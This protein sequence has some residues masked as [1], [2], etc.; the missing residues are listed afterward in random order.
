MQPNPLRLRSIHHVEFW[1]G[2]AK[3]AA[4]FYRQ[5]FGFSQLAYAGLE[6]GQ[7]AQASY[8]LGQGRIRFVMSTPLSPDHPAA[9]HLRAHGDGVCDIAF[10]VDDADLAFAEAVRRGAAVAVEPRTLADDHGA[11]RHAAVRAY[12][13]TVHSFI[14]Y[15]TYNGPFLPGFVEAPRPG[16]DLGLLRID[17]IVGNVELGRMNDWAEWYQRVLGFE[18]FL[19][20]EDKDISTEYSALMSIVMADDSRAIKFPINEPAPGRRKSQIDEYLDFYRGPG[21]QHIALL[22]TDILSTVGRLSTRGVQFLR[23][24][25]SYYELL[26]SRVGSIDESTDKVRE[27]GILVDRDEEGYLLQ[28]FTQPVEDRPTLFFEIIERKGSRGFGKGNF[29]ALFESIEREQALRGNL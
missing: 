15:D 5:A 9:E 10:H 24:P 23:V 27:L 19:T 17:H 7:R 4:F 16:E 11:I 1:V 21:V 3:Q 22:T 13:D 6:T 25:D 20:F 26:P 14:S 8:V 28:L 29:R 12:G 18:R 2:N